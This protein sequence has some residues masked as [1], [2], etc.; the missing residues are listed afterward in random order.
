MLS[1]ETKR[2]AWPKRLRGRAKERC[3]CR[4]RMMIWKCN[5]EPY[6]NRQR[7]H[8]IGYG[9]VVRSTKRPYGIVFESRTIGYGEVYGV[10]FEARDR[11]SPNTDLWVV[12]RLGMM[13]VW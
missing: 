4:G 1:Q 7:D 11:R 13:V 5:G 2:L 8:T 3:L 9:V 12:V 10:G 6:G